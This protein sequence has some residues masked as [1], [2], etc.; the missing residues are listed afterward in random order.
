[1][2]DLKSG[3]SMKYSWDFPS[4]KDKK[5]V[6]AVGE[7]TRAVDI[8]EIGHQVPFRYRK[9]RRNPGILSIDVVARG[10]MQI[11]R[12]SDY[13]QSSSMFKLKS[14]AASAMGSTIVDESV[15]ETFEE[16]DVEH[17]IN[18]T[19]SVNLHGIGVSIINQRLQVIYK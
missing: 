16:V 2:Y 13:D 7:R 14:S 4:M 17:V 11:L 12:L 10:P 18:Y 19:I 3:A 9:S 15:R 1:V 8:K 6:L 5:V